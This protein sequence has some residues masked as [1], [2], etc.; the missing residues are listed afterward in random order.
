MPVKLRPLTLIFLGSLA[1]TAIAWLLRGFQLLTGLP[2]MIL[3][4]LL[5]FTLL[6]GVVTALQELR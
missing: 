6:A 4:V 3:L 1:I 2:G 5:L